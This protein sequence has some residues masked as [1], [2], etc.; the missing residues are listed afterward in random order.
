MEYAR[1]PNLTARLHQ[2]I[3]AGFIPD[4]LTVVAYSST[5]AEGLHRLHVAGKRAGL[6]KGRRRHAAAM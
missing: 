6:L 5:G 2:L 1:G 3:D 4:F